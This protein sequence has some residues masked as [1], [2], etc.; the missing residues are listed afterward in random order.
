MKNRIGL[1]Q[2][3]INQ[4]GEQSS[5]LR[6][7][8]EEVSEQKSN[9][10]IATI[11]LQLTVLTSLSYATSIMYDLDIPLGMCWRGGCIAY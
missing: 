6:E 9:L 5:E 4:I 3:T 2:E 10:R 11:P 8:V 7:W 1:T